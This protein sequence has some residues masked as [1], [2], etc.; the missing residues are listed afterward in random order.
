MRLSSRLPVILAAACGAAALAGLYVGLDWWSAYPPGQTATYVGR[1]KCAECHQKEIEDWEDSDHDR[2]MDLATPEFV[3]GDFDNQ[4][5]LEFAL[6]DLGKLSEEDLR[7][8][9]EAVTP[10]Q[11]ALVL[12]STAAELRERVLASLSEARRD[13]IARIQGNP[14]PVRPSDVTWARQDA[15]DA[16]RRLEREG[17]VA[18]DFGIRSRMFREGE[19]FFVTTDGPSGE[20]ETYEVKYVFGY[21]PLQQYLVEFPDGTRLRDGSELPA[22]SFQCLRLCWDTERKRWFCQYPGE[23]VPAGDELH[24]TGRLQNWNFM[25]ADC[26]S[27]NL[28]RNYDLEENAYHTTFSEIDVSCETCHGPGSLHVELA[29]SN[30][31]FWDRR[32]GYGLPK[33]KDASNLPQLNSCAPCHS[34][35]RIVYPDRPTEKPIDTCPRPLLDA[36]V[37][38]L[39]DHQSPYLAN[40]RVYYADGQ[41]LEEDY[42]YGS[43]IQ[44]KMFHKDVRC[45]DC[46]DPHSTRVK[47]E[48]P[49]DNRLCT[50][51]HAAA[52]PSGKYD[53]VAHH[54]HPDASQPGTRCVECHMDDTCYMV[55]DARRDH[56]FRVPRPDLTVSL[57]IPNACNRCHHDL[58]KGETPQWAADKVREWYGKPE[59]EKH[60]AFA[61]SAGRAHQSGTDVALLS[62]LRRKDTPAIVRA[63]ALL[64]L[65]DYHT[66]NH[67]TGAEWGLKDDDPLVRLTATGVLPEMPGAEMARLLGPLLRDPVRAVRTEAARALAR[68]PAS[69]IPGMHREAF[70][71]ALDEY[72]QGL[73]CQSDQAAAHF[74]MALVYDGQGEPMKAVEAYETALRL[75]PRLL[76]ARNNLG[77]LY[78]QIQRYDS[79]EKQYRAG[80]AIN[81]DFVQIRDNLARLYYGQGRLV[82][83]EAEFRKIIELE[84]EIAEVHYALGLLLAEDESRLEEAA[85]ALSE[86]ARLAPGNGRVRYNYGLAL[87]KLGRPDQAE[88]E[89][90]AA[91]RLEPAAEDYVHALYVLYSQQGRWEEAVEAARRLV[92]IRPDVPQLRSLLQQAEARARSVPDR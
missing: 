50:D 11:W 42:V 22:G 86:A 69:H 55:N 54:H 14:S 88:S 44:S 5:Y 33:L 17:K 90:T 92:A 16:I 58:S 37:P 79:A 61:I 67:R 41:I 25:C 49:T 40:R 59:R 78:G 39:F 71:K 7:T 31:L 30:S 60:F 12:P 81:P 89:L 27:T 47:T 18:I 91:S 72:M 8:V 2:A 23:A 87:Q 3:L 35:R 51:C 65:G 29:E 64:L 15:C 32:H 63:S 10:A 82:E 45:T 4:E 53:T 36:Y 76:L 19:K 24:W 48:D 38:S 77:R 66:P 73:E 84:P 43:F 56:S 34:R 6:D 21:R 46:H 13:A 1:Q 70:Q 74:S 57:G 68:V 52:H 83:A 26:H 75:D 85:R 28:Q 62:V 20:L 80:I 9:A